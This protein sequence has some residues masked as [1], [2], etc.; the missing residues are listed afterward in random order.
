MTPSPAY[1]SDTVSDIGLT[2]EE[3][4]ERVQLADSFHQQFQKISH[5]DA[6]GLHVARMP[7]W[8]AKF[9]RRCGCV[10]SAVLEKIGS[11]SIAKRR[12]KDTQLF[13]AHV[14]Q[15]FEAG[16]PLCFRVVVG[17]V[18]NVQRCGAQQSPDIAEYLMFIQLARVME[19]V[20]A[21]YPHGVSVQLV[22]DDVRGGIANDW[23]A[24]YGERYIAGLQQM[25]R[26][27][28]F[29]SWLRVENGQT[30]LY[31]RY[32]VENYMDAAKASV[33][34][35]ACFSANFEMACSKARDNLVSR[36]SKAPSENDVRASAMRYLT[37]HK[38]ELLSGMWSPGET[39][40]LIYA[41]HPGS[42]QLYTMGR[43]LTKL[44]WQVRMPFSLLDESLHP[45]MSAPLAS[46]PA[47]A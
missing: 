28:G 26:A 24:A 47:I 31:Q 16:A 45:V 23:P 6:A 20:A 5:V 17:P 25:V 1:L 22:P 38:A 9:I 34:S 11:N 36:G 42:Y 33:I 8:G 30:K 10:P 43:G 7:Q 35:D 13:L 41:N 19:S 44:P 21:I 46:F 3:L 29:A 15:R 37:A 32:Q 4:R 40:P 12:P 39:F 14:R 18:K 2:H 27:L